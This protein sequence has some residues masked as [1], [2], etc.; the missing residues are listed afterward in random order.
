MSDHSRANASAPIGQNP[1][2]CSV[3][4]DQNHHPEALVRV[5]RIAFILLSFLMVLALSAAY[6]R[7]GGLAWMQAMFYGIGAALIGIIARSAFKPNLSF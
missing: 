6:V 2:H 3:Q 7:F 1:E 5:S 4:A